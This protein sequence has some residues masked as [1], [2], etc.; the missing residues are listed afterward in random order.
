M[1]EPLSAPSFLQRLNPLTKVIAA[2][3]LFAV[4]ASLTNPLML[5]IICLWMVVVVVGLGHISPKLLLRRSL[6]LLFF[7][8]TQFT[9]YPF[10]I[11]PELLVNS[12][13]VF[14]IGGLAVH[15]IGL[16]AT[17]IVCLRFVAMFLLCL[18]FFL[19]TEAADFVRAL[20]QHARLN[21]RLGLLVLASYRFFPLFKEEFA[22]VR[23]AHHMRGEQRAFWMV[24]ILRKPLR[25][26]VPVFVSV[27]RKAER[28]ALSLDAR[29]FGAFSTR[30]F[31]RQ[32][33][34]HVRDGAFLVGFWAM[35]A[36]VLLG[37]HYVSSH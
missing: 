12:P 2:L 25:I 18:L 20:M 24:R 14:H 34:F 5:G 13:V 8:F 37:T 29:A 1:N 10:V 11:K 9:Y 6:F 21:Y 35:F 31:Y 3:P 33:P 28:M 30:T 27:V 4:I 22:R 15:R 17:G 23:E 36:L 26:L 7:V 16:V 19:T 32:L